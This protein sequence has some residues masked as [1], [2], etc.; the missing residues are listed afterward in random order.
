MLLFAA[1]LLSSPAAPE[2]ATSPFERVAIVGASASSGWGLRGEWGVSLDMQ[3]FVA[4]SLVEAPERLLGLGDGFFFMD[5]VMKGP[6]QIDKALAIE[7][8]LVVALDFLFWF[9]YGDVSDAYRLRRL[10]EGLRE[11]DTFECPILVGDL[12]DM[13]PATEGTSPIGPLI[14][15]A[16]IPPPEVLAQLNERIRAWASERE[17]VVVVPLTALVDRARTDTELELLGNRWEGDLVSQFTQADLLHPTIEGTTVML[18]VAY[19]AALKARPGWAEHLVL[20][21]REIE[22]RLRA[23]HADALERAAKRA[24]RRAERAAERAAQQE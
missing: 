24:A 7:P 12:P 10:D 17:R 4:A 5:P 9:G 20:D 8:T 6:K 2:V 1:L 3:D 23:A 18:L 11:L 15:P 13:S 21:A 22:R 16:Q 19:E 14:F